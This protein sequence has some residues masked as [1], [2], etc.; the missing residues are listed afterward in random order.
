MNKVV[1]MFGAMTLL[2]MMFSQAMFAQMVQWQ[3]EQASALTKLAA[4]V[5]G[6]EAFGNGTVR[7]QP[8]DADLAPGKTVAHTKTL[9]DMHTLCFGLLSLD[10]NPLHFN[11]VLARRTRFGGRIAHGFHTASLF[12]GVLAE[13]TPWC[14]Y[15]QQQLEFTAPV[16]S[17]DVI[18]ATGTI[19]EV[20]PKGV[21]RVALACTNQKG[22]V[23]VRGQAVVKKLKEMYQPST[24]AA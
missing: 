10:L 1:D 16:R 6:Q 15:L 11:E 2:P 9:T 24:P 3:R 20:D 12:S 14:V 4:S 8:Q 17:G 18:T 22:E 5:S 13:L 23:V 7:R 21:V 19:E